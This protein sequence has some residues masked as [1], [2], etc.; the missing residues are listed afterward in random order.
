MSSDIINHTLAAWNFHALDYIDIKLLIIPGNSIIE[1]KLDLNRE[2]MILLV[3][4]LKEINST[5]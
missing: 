2:L 4:A 1:N 3:Y 5:K